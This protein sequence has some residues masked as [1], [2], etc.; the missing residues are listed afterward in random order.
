MQYELELAEALAGGELRQG[1]RGQRHI[2]GLAAEHPD[3]RGAGQR[4]GLGEVA[5][6]CDRQW[7]PVGQAEQGGDLLHFGAAQL[8]DSGEPGHE[9]GR[10]RW[11]PIAQQRRSRL[12]DRVGEVRLAAY[13]GGR[14][15]GVRAGQAQLEHAGSTDERCERRQTLDASPPRLSPP[16]FH[17]PAHPRGE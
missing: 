16:D 2:A 13:D 10:R 17:E 9:A 1:Q 8:G 7:Q 4:D 11:E 5:V 12:R 14:L 6:G 15:H 3:R